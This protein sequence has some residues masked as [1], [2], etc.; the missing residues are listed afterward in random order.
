MDKDVSNDFMFV[1]L[2][3]FTTT[4]AILVLLDC[5][6]DTDKTGTGTSFRSDQSNLFAVLF[7]LYK[8]V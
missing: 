8:F 1:V 5:V 3:F 6:F 7:L 2:E 4:P